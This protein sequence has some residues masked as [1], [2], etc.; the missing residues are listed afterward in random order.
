MIIIRTG[1]VFQGALVGV[2][3][4]RGARA[5]PRV[6]LA[7]RAQPRLDLLS[8]LPANN[9]LFINTSHSLKSVPNLVKTQTQNKKQIIVT[10]DSNTY[11]AHSSPMSQSNIPNDLWFANPKTTL[12]NIYVSM[13]L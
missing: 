1:V 7:A 4:V 9:N 10:P 8:P 13:D 2:Q 6:L 11:S 5:R 12:P 3:A